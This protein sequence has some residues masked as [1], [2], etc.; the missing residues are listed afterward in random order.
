[1]GMKTGQKIEREQN[2]QI[3]QKTKE[4]FSK[5]AGKLTAISPALFA[6]LV[7]FLVL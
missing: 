5:I 1:M 6:V 2:I 3:R 4:T 7:S